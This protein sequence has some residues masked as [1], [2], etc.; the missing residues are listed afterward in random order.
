MILTADADSSPTAEKEL[1]D[2]CGLG[3][4]H[5]SR[6][7]D[8]SSGYVRHLWEPDDDRNG[9]AALFEVKFGKNAERTITVP[10]ERSAEQ[11]IGTLQSVALAVESSDLGTT[12]DLLSLQQ[13]ASMTP[14]RGNC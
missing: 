9:H 6:S 13:D 3:R 11:L 5:S 12:E 14:R 10:R 8:L 1:L 4:C 7:N 2:D